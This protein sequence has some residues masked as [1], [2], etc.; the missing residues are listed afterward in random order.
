MIFPLSPHSL[1]Q[2]NA[3]EVFLPKY[4]IKGRVLMVDGRG[5][6]RPPLSGGEQDEVR[7]CDG[8]C[9]SGEV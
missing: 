6:V 5:L 9:G 1:V 8:R 7:A 2:G 4:Q 3:L